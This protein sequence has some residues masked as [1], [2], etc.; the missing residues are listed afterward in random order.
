[1]QYIYSVEV[2]SDLFEWIGVLCGVLRNITEL[3]WTWTSL[4]LD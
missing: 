2:V 1:M 3:R 4:T